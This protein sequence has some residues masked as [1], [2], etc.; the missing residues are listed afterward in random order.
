MAV[1]STSSS[2]SRSYSPPTDPLTIIQHALASGQG[3]QLI[4][5]LAAQLKANEFIGQPVAVPHDFDLSHGSQEVMY[6]T[7]RN[8]PRKELVFKIAPETIM[9][10]AI[11]FCLEVWRND[12]GVRFKASELFFYLPCNNKIDYYTPLT[13]R[14]LG[15]ENHDLI[16][17][18]SESHG[19]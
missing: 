13:A 9:R 5:L 1:I 2:R 19:G 7:F 15:V 3:P 8:G 10:Q 14:Q 6:V 18:F 16:D 4:E 11:A 17:V 12:W